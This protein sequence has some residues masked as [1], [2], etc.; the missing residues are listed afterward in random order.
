M[1]IALL[2]SLGVFLV[3]MD[4]LITYKLYKS[5]E[6]EYYE[7]YKLLY[8]KTMSLRGRLFELEDSV[9]RKIG[10]ALAK[11]RRKRKSQEKCQEKK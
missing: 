4:L 3:F 6:S 8:E 5:V 2:F 1:A 7:K 11:V 9:D 10:A